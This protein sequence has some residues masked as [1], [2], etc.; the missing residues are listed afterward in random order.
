MGT[1]F[2]ASLFGLAGALILGFLDLT[3]GQA[4]NRFFNEL[5]EWLAGLTRLSS[6]A[7]ADGEGSVPVYVQA[8]LEQTA[9]NMES[10][11]RVLL[12]G[13]DSRQQAQLTMAGLNEQ[14]GV[15]GRCVAQPVSK[16]CCVWPKTA[17]GAMTS[18]ASHLRN[19]ELWLQ[20]MAAEAEQGRSETTADLRNDLRVLT[21]TVA[22]L[23]EEK[24]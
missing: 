16:R 4:Q 20:R 19:I 3:A 21:R 11:R 2:S 23:A 7:L 17:P 18:R 9:E 14:I 1:A 24:R 13:E 8:L 12:R 22:A 10:L 5:E 6:G 15:A